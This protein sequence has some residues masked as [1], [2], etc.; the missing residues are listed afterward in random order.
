MKNIFFLTFIL[1][2]S[3]SFFSQELV[4]KVRRKEKESDY[5]P[6]ISGIMHGDI[7]SEQVCGNPLTN[8]KKWVIHSYVISTEIINKG[9]PFLVESAYVPNEI[10][11]LLRRGIKTQLF[12]TDVRARDEFGNEYRLENVFFNVR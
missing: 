11:Q 4:L 10:C 9:K 3:T 6:Q 8:Q 2:Y 1:F 12:I 5:Y 7:S